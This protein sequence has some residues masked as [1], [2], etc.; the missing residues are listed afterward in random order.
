MTIQSPRPA[1]RQGMRHS[2]LAA[3]LL[4]AVDLV[5]RRGGLLCGLH[6]ADGA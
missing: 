1:I 5:L 2:A 4:S 3:A 6:A